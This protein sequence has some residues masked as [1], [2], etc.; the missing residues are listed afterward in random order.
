MVGCFRKHSENPWI[1]SITSQVFIVNTIITAKLLNSCLLS[2]NVLDFKVAPCD[3]NNANMFKL[4]SLDAQME[5]SKPH[6]QLDGGRGAGFWPIRFR[7]KGQANSRPALKNLCGSGFTSFSHWFFH[8]T[9]L[10]SF[11]TLSNFFSDFITLW[12]F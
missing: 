2:C 10:Q 6:L 5:V 9:M 7:Q 11:S 3:S 12:L 8:P 4:F 1:V